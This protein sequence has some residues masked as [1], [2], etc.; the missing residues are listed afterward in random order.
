MTLVDL[1]GYVKDVSFSTLVIAIL[2]GSYK[3]IWVWGWQLEAAEKQNAVLFNLALRA[4]DVADKTTPP[5]PPIPLHR[6]VD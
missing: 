6:D 5:L 1:L 4:T 3:R 2:W